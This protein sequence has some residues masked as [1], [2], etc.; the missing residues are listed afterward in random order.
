MDLKDYKFNVG[1]EVITTE[2][3]RGRITGICDCSECQ[4]RGF[5]EPF[6][7]AEDHRDGFSKCIDKFT[8]SCGFVGFYKIGEYRFNDFDKGE[9]LRNM[10]YCETELRRLNKQLKLIE[11][12]EKDMFQVET[13]LSG[14]VLNSNLAVLD[15][16]HLTDEEI[17]KIVDEFNKIPN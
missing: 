12:L 15:C 13:K 4:K 16:S 2:G 11:E 5:Y 7:V 8:A 3:V 6:W 17:D 9:V 14:A 10:G 1:D